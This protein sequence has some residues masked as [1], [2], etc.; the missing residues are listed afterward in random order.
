MSEEKEIQ[1]KKHEAERFES[2]SAI[3]TIALCPVMTLNQHCIPKIISSKSL[4]IH[5]TL[6]MIILKPARS[7]STIKIM[8]F[9]PA[10]KGQR[11]T[12]D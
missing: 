4:S 8:Y 1:L 7:T 5:V 6:H 10:S 12:L 2:V 11:C 3:C 9:N